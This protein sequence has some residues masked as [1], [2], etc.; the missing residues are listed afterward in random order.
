[1]PG[2]HFPPQLLE[3][4]FHLPKGFCPMT[5]G[6]SDP[7]EGDIVWTICPPMDG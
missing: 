5:G 1:M 4:F 7:S 3:F 6:I 2:G